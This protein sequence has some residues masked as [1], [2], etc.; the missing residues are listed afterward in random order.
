M[1]I[2]LMELRRKDMSDRPTQE[3]LNSYANKIEAR[4]SEIQDDDYRQLCFYAINAA[5]LLWG[6]LNSPFGED[7]PL[8]YPGGLLE[9]TAVSFGHLDGLS[10]QYNNHELQFS[11]SLATAGCLLRNIGWHTT[12]LYVDG[13]LKKRD[14]YYTTG[15]WR[16]AFR[17]VDHLILGCESDLQIKIPEAKKQALENMCNNE[18]DIYTQEGVIVCAANYLADNLLNFKYNSHKTTQNWKGP[19]FVGHNG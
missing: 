15:V 17:Y 1:K 18:A 14:S 3:L 9:Y 8:A 12:T 10:A 16:S 19:H 5:D 4:I 2:E 13:V 7:G 6:L 11:K